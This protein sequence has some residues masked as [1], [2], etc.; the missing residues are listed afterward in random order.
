MSDAHALKQVGADVVITI[1]ANDSI[2][3]NH[4]NLSSLHASDFHIV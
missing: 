2:T 3:L 1:D 4:V